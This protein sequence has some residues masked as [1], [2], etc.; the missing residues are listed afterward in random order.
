MDAQGEAVDPNIYSSPCAVF[1]VPKSD[2]KEKKMLYFQVIEIKH[3]VKQ[4]N[5]KTWSQQMLLF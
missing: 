4:N 2:S 5:I 1:I 3:N